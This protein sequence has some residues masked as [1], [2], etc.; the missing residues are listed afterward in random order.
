MELNSSAKPLPGEIG[1]RREV[2]QRVRDLMM[3]QAFSSREREPKD[4]KA[5]ITA[6]SIE[7]AGDGDVG[8]LELVSV[9]QP[10]GSHMS[11]LEVVYEC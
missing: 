9:N 6:A 8:K 7:A 11:I 3:L 2:M 5:L 4:W 1:A 10:F